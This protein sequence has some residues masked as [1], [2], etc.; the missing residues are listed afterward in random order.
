MKQ[1]YYYFL[2]R[3][4]R[5]YKDKLKEDDKNASFATVCVSSIILFFNL[6]SIYVLV[7]Y[8]DIIPMFKNKYWV[9]I[10]LAV[11]AI[12]NY[13]FFIRKKE[14]LDCGFTKNKIG[15]LKIIAYYVISLVIFITIACF[16]RH[17][18]FS[19]MPPPDPN[20]PRPESLEGK[21]RDWIKNL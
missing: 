2:F 6:F 1:A 7:D 16:N 4:F 15:T 11:I 14:F 19:N 21:I 10:I 3:T 17:K 9:I 8:L 5:Y 13:Y 20:Q 18:T 12:L